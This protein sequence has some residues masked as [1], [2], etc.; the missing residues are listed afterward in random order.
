MKENSK[1]GGTYCWG[2]PNRNFKVLVLLLCILW[3]VAPYK[4]RW[5]LEWV[6]SMTFMTVQLDRNHKNYF[7]D[8][9][10]GWAHAHT[11]SKLVQRR[12]WGKSSVTFLPWC[13]WGFALDCFSKLLGISKSLNA[14]VLGVSAWGSLLEGFNWVFFFLLDP[15]AHSHGSSAPCTPGLSHCDSSP[16]VTIE[17]LSPEEGHKDQSSEAVWIWAFG[18]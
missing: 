13:L 10:D 17:V 2:L 9:R 18:S 14:S 7:N 4:G 16:A 3:A 11:G 5:G 6:L 15:P 8:R 1:P 12:C